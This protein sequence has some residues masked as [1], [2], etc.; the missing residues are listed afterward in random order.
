MATSYDGSIKIDTQIDSGNMAAGMNRVNTAIQKIMKNIIGGLTAAASVALSVVAVI[1]TIAAAL[2]GAGI[3]AY[4][5]FENMT[6]SMAKTLSHTS[7]YYSEV[8]NL[9]GAFDNVKGSLQA[10]FSTLLTAA[11]PALMAVTGFLVKILNTISMIVAALTGQKTVMQY[12]SGSAEGVAKSTGNA[13]KNT[14]KMG[15]AA[16]GALAAFDQLNVLQ[17]ADDNQGGGAGNGGNIMMKEVVVAQGIAATIDSIKKW[18]AQAWTDIINF[19]SPVLEWI[20]VNVIQP[21][22]TSFAWLWDIIKNSALAFWNGGLKKM[23][24]DI[25]NF[26]GGLFSGQLKAFGDMIGNIFKTLLTTLTGIINGVIQILGGLIMFIT[27]VFTGNWKKAWEGIKTIFTGVFNTIVTF[28]GGSI[29]IMIDLINGMI[30]GILSGLNAV[31]EAMN[32]IK[33]NIPTWVPGLGGK[34]FGVNLGTISPVRIPYIPIPKLATGAVIPPNA[35]FAAILGDQKHGTN[36]EAPLETI[37]QAV[38]NALA[39]SGQNEPMVLK[40]EMYLD[41]QIVYENQRKIERRMG[42]SLITHNAV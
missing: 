5:F 29:N 18:M 41:G 22:A 32:K 39:A 11:T 38:M 33:V 10:A 27:G 35:E 34:S 36:I 3:A 1:T 14:R 30:A 6:Y 26:L 25:L 16:K 12:V 15:E 28:I 37:T 21:I 23:L 31:I 19:L 42:M 2:L 17:M 7:A 20:N 24:E 13:A 4:K 40:N 8:L 9:K